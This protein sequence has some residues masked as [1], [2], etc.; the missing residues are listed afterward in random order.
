V[1]RL[2]QNTPKR[3]RISALKRLAKTAGLR[4]KRVRTSL[5]LARAPAAF[6]RGKRQLKAVQNQEDQGQID[7]C[8]FDE[9]GFSLNPTLPYA[10]QAA[11]DVIMATDQ[12]QL[13]AVLGL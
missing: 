6:E 11:R 10:W 13:A 9:A 1:D 8:Y 7:W 2:T 5:K 4:G 12:I 3:I